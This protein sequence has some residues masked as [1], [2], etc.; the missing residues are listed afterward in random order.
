MNVRKCM[1]KKFNDIQIQVDLNLLHLYNVLFVLFLH[2]G[3]L[4]CT[5][6]SEFDYVQ[7]CTCTVYDVHEASC[8]RLA[9]SV[10][11]FTSTSMA[12]SILLTSTAVVGPG[13]SIGK[14]L[15]LN[16]KIRPNKNISGSGERTDLCSPDLPT[17][18]FQHAIDISHFKFG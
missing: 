12:S 13:N 1:S 16:M 17:L 11:F 8:M 10:D 3:Y 5:N 9:K 2:I 4:Y 14:R 6:P 7:L 15:V 18:I